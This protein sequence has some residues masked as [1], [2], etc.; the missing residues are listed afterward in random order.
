[1]FVKHAE[2]GKITVLIVYVD[3]IVL[4]GNHEKEITHVKALLSKEFEMKDHGNLRYFLGMEVARS[5]GIAISQRK[6]VLDLL[7]E[8]G[9]LGS[10]PTDTPMDANVKLGVRKDCPLADK[11]R[12]QRLVGKL[13]YLTHTRPTLDL[14]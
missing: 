14:L 8:T 4:T 12:Y 1:M 10:K 9:M 13:R 2:E 3:D 5:A 11:G 6:Y 7:T